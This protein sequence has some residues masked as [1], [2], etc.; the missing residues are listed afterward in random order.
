[1]HQIGKEKD[2]SSLLGS[3]AR[4]FVPVVEPD[5]SHFSEIRVSATMIT[6]HLP[7]LYVSELNAMLHDWAV[8]RHAQHHTSGLRPPLSAHTAQQSEEP[9]DDR[10]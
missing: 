6:D 1:M 10:V 9:S 2:R 4:V 7:D 8:E 5:L 3:V